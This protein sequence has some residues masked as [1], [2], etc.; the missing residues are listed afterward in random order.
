M[1]MFSLLA[2]F[3]EVAIEQGLGT[4]GDEMRL[5]IVALDLDGTVLDASG[6]LIDNVADGVRR[7]RGLGMAAV[8]L[9]GRSAIAFRALTDVGDLLS[10]CE[11]EVLVDDGDTVFDRRTAECR[12]LT[13][14]PA[15][16]VEAVGA[17][18]SDFVVGQPDRLI[19]SSRLALRAY[20]LAHR[21]SPSRIDI[22]T[23]DGAASRI[24]VFGSPPPAVNGVTAETIRSFSAVVL[25]PTDGG[26]SAGLARWLDARPGGVRL[27]DVMAIGD[28][29]N[30]VSL[31]SASGLGVA[32]TTGSPRAV[33]AADLHLAEPLGRFLASFQP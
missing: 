17:R 18:A 11:P 6:R 25:R 30:D 20:A 33:A 3:R 21:L 10:Q 1:E 24:T 22:G 23:P 4:I 8:V 31:L 12:A 19:A 29:D 9:T 7:L 2:R 16:T 32:V 28:A 26:K 27:T 5:R 15:G 13:L 14:L